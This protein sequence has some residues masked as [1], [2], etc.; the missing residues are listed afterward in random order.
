MIDQDQ[1]SISAAFLEVLGDSTAIRIE[2]HA[3]DEPVDEDVEG[4]E[5][6]R[7]VVIPAGFGSALRAGEPV[8]LQ[9]I[10]RTRVALA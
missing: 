4:G 10:I 5:I 3:V 2:M 6:L 1:S 8:D 7:R 9:V